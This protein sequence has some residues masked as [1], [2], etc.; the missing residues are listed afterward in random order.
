M[1]HGMPDD[2]NIVY[3]ENLYRSDD[4][5]ELAIRLGAPGAYI[6]SGH[7]IWQ[8]NFTQGISQWIQMPLGVDSVALLDNAAWVTGGVGLQLYADDSDPGLILL[9][10]LVGIPY[11]GRYGLAAMIILDPTT[12]QISMG[13]YALHAFPRQEYRITYDHVAK[14]LAYFSSAGAE[15][16][17]ADAV[18]VEDGAIVAYPAKLVFDSVKREYVK[19]FFAGVEYDLSGLGCRTAAV[20]PTWLIAL[21]FVGESTGVNASKVWL[22]DIIL[23]IDE[24]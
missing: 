15:V 4:L 21:R 7:V 17:F 1:P 8:D 11:A 10:R 3:E 5:G 13:C 24:P 12:Y 23:S 16:V 20:A 14:T 2:G 9:T 6:R 22:D 18:A 19:F